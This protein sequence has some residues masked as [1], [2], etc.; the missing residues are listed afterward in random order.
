MPA[1]IFPCTER[2][3]YPDDSHMNI[4]GKNVVLRAIEL[5]DLAALHRWSNDPEIQ[6]QLGGWHFPLSKRSLATWVETFRHDGVDQRFVIEVPEKGPVG[7]VSLTSINWKD[8]NAFHGVLIGERD[9]QGKGYAAAAVIAI[10]RYAFEE[11]GLQRLDT[12]IV[13]YNTGSLALHKEKLGWTEEGRKKDA[14]YR[15]N[16]HWA[17]V[18]LGITRDEYAAHLASGKF[19]QF[20]A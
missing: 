14:V 7:I 2:R 18:V 13:E 3:Q 10:M 4:H 11:L 19:D 1:P 17:N 15:K 12:T 9:Q 8:R 6:S 5:E 16:R 20:K